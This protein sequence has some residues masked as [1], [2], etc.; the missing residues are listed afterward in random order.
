[1]REKKSEGKCQIGPRVRWAALLS[2]IFEREIREGFFNSLLK[3]IMVT[4]KAWTIGPEEER[5]ASYF[6]LLFSSHYKKC[7]GWGCL[8]FSVPP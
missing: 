1:M 2:I 3:I 5:E 6:F 7:I 4:C 8:G